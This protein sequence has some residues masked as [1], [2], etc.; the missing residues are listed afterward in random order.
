[1]IEE[2]AK[3]ILEQMGLQKTH[4]VI[5][6]G[7]AIEM[8]PHAHSLCATSEEVLPKEEQI[9][10]AQDGLGKATGI[11]NIM[12][13]YGADRVI[14]FMLGDSPNSDGPAMK[15]C[16]QYDGYGIAVE[17]G[18]NLPDD[19]RM[20]TGDR[21]IPNFHMTWD[22]IAGMVDH[23]KNQPSNVVLMQRGPVAARG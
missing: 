1:M 10:I 18:N 9:R 7:D 8:A 17:N 11:H 12:S 21:V 16:I 23:L 4:R 15:T 20:A 14:P 2:V 3:P 6:G 19:F 13:L 5:A 22:H